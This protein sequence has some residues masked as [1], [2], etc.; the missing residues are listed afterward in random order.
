MVS[1][2]SPEA[3]LQA[4]RCLATVAATRVGSIISIF[5]EVLGKQERSFPAIDVV[6]DSWQHLGGFEFSPNVLIYAKPKVAALRVRA[7]KSDQE[8]GVAVDHAIAA[9]EALID[10]WLTATVCYS[11]AVAESISVALEFDRK[12]VRPPE[13]SSSWVGFELAGQAAEAERVYRTQGILDENEVFEIRMSAG[14]SAMQYRNI[15]VELSD[16]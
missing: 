13:G 5:F 4:E 6:E 11:T 14:A 7:R 1:K 8:W 9:A 2:I 12:S 3:A 15:L 16:F 10:S